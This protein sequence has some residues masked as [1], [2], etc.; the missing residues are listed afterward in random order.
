MKLSYEN[1]NDF[2]WE[3]CLRFLLVVVEARCCDG[4][5]FNDVD[6]A[7]DDGRIDECEEKTSWSW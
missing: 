2:R 3:K 6:E 1:K 4:A 5:K 7:T